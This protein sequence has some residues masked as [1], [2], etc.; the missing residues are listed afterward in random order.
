MAKVMVHVADQE[1]AIDC[2]PHQQRRVADL[3]ALLE[4]RLAVFAGEPETLRRLVLTA[5]ALMDE[6][7]T[8]GAALARARGEI[9]RL[10]DLVCDVEAD[11]G[12]SDRAMSRTRLPE[13]AA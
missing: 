6:A 11:Q 3:A 10:N 7:Q 9:D 12:G 4:S 2:A 5:L 8:A 1:I 13:G